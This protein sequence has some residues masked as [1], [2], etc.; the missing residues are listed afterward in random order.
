MKLAAYDPQTFQVD[1]PLWLIFPNVQPRLWYCK[2]KHNNKKMND[3]G[4]IHQLTPDCPLNQNSW[5]ISALFE[6]LHPSTAFTVSKA[7]RTLSW[8]CCC[9]GLQPGFGLARFFFSFNRPNSSCCVNHHLSNLKS[10]RNFSQSP[11][12]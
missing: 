5:R 3:W 4:Y 2:L 6:W 8:T 9:A 10:T 12:L 1:S 7:R 11:S